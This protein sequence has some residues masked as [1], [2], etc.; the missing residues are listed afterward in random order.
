[1]TPTQAATFMTRLRGG[2]SVRHVTGGGKL[3]RAVS[4]LKTIPSVP[5][6]SQ[7]NRRIDS[8]HETVE[9]QAFQVATALRSRRL[10]GAPS[11]HRRG[12]GA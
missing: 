3:G 1:M 6:L 11:L 9:Q 10:Q 12:A 2:D 8:V 5:L 4:S 7:F